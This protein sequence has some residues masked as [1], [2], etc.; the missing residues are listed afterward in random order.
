MTFRKVPT[1]T[2]GLNTTRRAGDFSRKTGGLTLLFRQI[3]ELPLQPNENDH[4]MR[5]LEVAKWR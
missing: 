4:L 1:K 2:E 5:R 3:P